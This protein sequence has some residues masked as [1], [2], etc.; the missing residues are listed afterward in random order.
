MA[1]K[2]V[3]NPPQQGL[4]VIWNISTHV[5]CKQGKCFNHKTD[6]ELVKFLIAQHQKKI[7]FK[8]LTPSCKKPSLTVNGEFDAVL[9]F[10]IYAYQDVPGG[11]MD[12]VVSP[13][14]GVSYGSAMW[15]ISWLNGSLMTEA[16]QIYMQLDTYPELSAALRGELKRTTP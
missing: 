11:V 4:S 13:A 6:V 3:L 5:G 14:H 16:P 15:L 12:G 10:W 2:L 9:A 1:Y 8:K 7:P